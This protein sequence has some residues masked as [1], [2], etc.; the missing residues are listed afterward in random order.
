MIV[1]RR[2]YLKAKLISG[3]INGKL[4]ICTCTKFTKS[5]KTHKNGINLIYFK[6]NDKGFIAGGN[7]DILLLWENKIKTIKKYDIKLESVHSLNPKIRSVCENDNDNL[8]IGTK[9]GEII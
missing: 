3:S 2:G 5:I 8:L 9:S 6:N 1:T 4:L 7:G